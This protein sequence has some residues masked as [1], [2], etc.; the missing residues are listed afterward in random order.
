MS[1]QDAIHLGSHGTQHAFAHG[2]T[3]RG[4]SHY[5]TV[6]DTA[7]KKN[8][9]IPLEHGGKAF[10]LSQIKKVAGKEVH[11]ELLKKIHADHKEEL[12]SYED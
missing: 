10:T 6:H 5:Y 4:E 8:H 2:E 9:D 1:N 12:S 7:T 3:D 11:P